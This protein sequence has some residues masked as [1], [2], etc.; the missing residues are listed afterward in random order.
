MSRLKIRKAPAE[1]DPE[2]DMSPL[3]DVAFL[4]LIYFL[5][6]ST[7]DP[8]EADLGMQLPTTV[9]TSSAQVEVDQ[10]TI[11][12]NGEGHIVVN[13]ETLDTD[14]A[15]RKV[16]KLAAKVGEYAEAAK[17][18]GSQP[19]VVVSADDA[20]QSQRFVDVLNALA[21]VGIKNVTITGFTEEG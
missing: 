6:T 17:L 7:L 21:G 14:I 8:K 16:P 10:M 13:D 19:I 4:L 9:S 15:D 3:I 1:K 5:V 2:L 12:V 11:E 18:T 20:S